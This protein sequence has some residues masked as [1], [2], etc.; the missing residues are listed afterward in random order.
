MLISKIKKSKPSNSTLFIGTDSETGDTFNFPTE[1]MY[2]TARGILYTKYE[3][4]YYSGGV[5]PYNIRFETQDTNVVRGFKIVKNSAGQASGLMALKT[6]VFCLTLCPFLSSSSGSSACFYLV[7]GVS[8][9]KYDIV[10]NSARIG[11][12][13]GLDNVDSNI[14]RWTIKVQKNDVVQIM[15]SGDP[16]VYVVFQNG[17]YTKLATVPASLKINEI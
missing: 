3:N 14:F 8:A 17:Y 4:F 6:G 12:S 2:S 16:G 7:S 13:R 15:L 9:N 10:P 5:I 1:Y 11:Y